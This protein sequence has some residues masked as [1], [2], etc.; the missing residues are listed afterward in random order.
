MIHIE[1]RRAPDALAQAVRAMRSTPDS[2]VN[3][4]ELKGEKRIVQESLVAEQHGL[5]AYCM[6]RIDAD[7]GSSIEHVIPQHGADGTDNLDKSL[8][9]GNMLAVCVPRGGVLTCDKSRGNRAL[10]VNPLDERTL[11]G[12]KYT[13][14]GRIGSDD[15]DIDHDL[16]VTLNLND[17]AA[18]LP[19]NRRAAWEHV[20]NRIAKF[21]KRGG[22]KG[23]LREC[24]RLKAAL[25]EQDE[26]A[27][28]IG[29]L[30]YRLDHFIDKFS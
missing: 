3:Y 19:Q 7:K 9:Y 30:L 5:C 1:K 28:Y 15:P 20:N 14:D 23:K 24:Q 4:G 21:A 25:L 27:E 29:V 8:D 12:I 10:K 22:E 11:S 2:S 6:R 26:Y 17:R 13:R 16:N 18:Y